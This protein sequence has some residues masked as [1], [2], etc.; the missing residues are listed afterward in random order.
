MAS[1]FQGG[2][3][4]TYKIKMKTN[5]EKHLGKIREMKER[6]VTSLTE[7]KFV[8]VKRELGRKDNWERQKSLKV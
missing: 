2:K 6:V 3:L 8:K 4:L 5:I 1:T 7:N